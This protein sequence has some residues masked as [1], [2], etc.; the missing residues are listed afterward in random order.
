MFH[1]FLGQ[2][3]NKISFGLMSLERHIN[4][5]R[6]RH[7]QGGNEPEDCEQAMFNC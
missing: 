5:V 3:P 7:V 1:K 6:E 4:R 2:A